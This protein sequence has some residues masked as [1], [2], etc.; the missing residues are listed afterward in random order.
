VSASL[1]DAG[2]RGVRGAPG[3]AGEAAC[4]DACLRRAWLLARLSGR[5]EG[6]RHGHAALPEVLALDDEA[7][8]RSVAGRRAGEVLAEREH[9]DARAAH[10]AVAAA[11]LTAVCRH[12][13]RFPPRLLHA[14]DA[15]AALFVGGLAQRLD[16]FGDEDERTVAIVGARRGSREALEVARALGRDL[17]LAGVPV[18]SGMALGVDSAAQAGALDAG[19]LSVA[20]LG[21]GAERA[22]PS[23][24]RRLHAAL[25]ERGLVLAELPP[26]TPPRRWTFPARNRIIAGL[27][28]LTVVV[29][30]AERS[31]SLITA[32][33]ALK[34]GREVAAVPGPV[35]SPGA[36]GSNELLRDGATLVRGVD[37]VLDALFGAGA[38]PRVRRAPGD[39]LE[40]H[41][42]VLLR[43]VADG[44]D[45]VAALTSADSPLVAQGGRREPGAVL[46]DLTE[47]ELRDLVR[48]DPGGRYRVRL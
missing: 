7:L 24:K 21:G 4:C 14:R 12:D 10:A 16:A 3:S 17:A 15:P 2:V 23:S 48:R 26:G 28:D 5:I 29:E 42:A 11:R 46:A 45:T 33:L 27:A 6:A 30:A 39:G 41:L 43:A 47:L 36:A 25:L 8:V 37:D 38:A 35:T 9:F 31:G 1:P 34:L 19:G 22:Y 44:H 13:R 20:V 18:V 32:E 40:S